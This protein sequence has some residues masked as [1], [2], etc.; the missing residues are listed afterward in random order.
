MRVKI[1][2]INSERDEKSLKFFGLQAIEKLQGNTQLDPSIYD[3]VFNAELDEADLEGIFTRFN[4]EGHPLHRG[5]SLSVSDIVVTD[6]GAFF[7][8]SIGFEA[9][10]F[11]ES[12]AHKPNNL[13]RIVYVEPHK[14]AYEA[15]IENSLKGEQRAVKGYIELVYN[16]DDTILVCNEEG[17][18][19]G[20]E[21]NRRLDNGVSIIAGPFFIVGDDGEDFRS[22]TDEETKKYL[23]RFAQPEDIS[24]EEV[25][26]DMGFTISGI[27]LF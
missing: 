7:C 1:Y 24:Q 20:M 23:E 9:V 22:L 25:E 17:K 5:H 11:D 27:N 2:Q 18:L 13:M 10:D 26:G 21:G 4:T 8:D 12:K 6:D 19:I 14:P 3:E 15:E 16:N